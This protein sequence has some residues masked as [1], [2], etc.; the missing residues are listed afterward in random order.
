M[1]NH[2]AHSESS[3]ASYSE[4]QQ[5][6]QQDLADLLGSLKMDARGTGKPRQPSSVVTGERLTMR[7]P[8]SEH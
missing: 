3:P 2:T 7:S 6:G 5:Y 4:E 1:H 8:I